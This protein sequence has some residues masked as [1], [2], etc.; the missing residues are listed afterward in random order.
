MPGTIQKFKGMQCPI[1]INK[2]DFWVG[3]S[4]QNIGTWLWFQRDLGQALSL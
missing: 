4:G 2:D 1:S 3:Q